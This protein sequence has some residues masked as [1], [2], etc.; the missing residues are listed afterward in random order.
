MVAQPAL[1]FNSP[2]RYSNQHFLGQTIEVDAAFFDRCVFQN[3]IMVYRGGP[4]PVF[5]HSTFENCQ[6]K[7]EGYAAF[8]LEY[9]STL[10]VTL[11]PD[12][13]S[14]IDAI[15]DNIKRGPAIR[16]PRF[17]GNGNQ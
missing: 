16:N 17:L 9:L 15:L 8:T 12:Q 13:R 5:F 7:F 14:L 2:S 1:T 4:P 10:A 6:W 11:P 3:C